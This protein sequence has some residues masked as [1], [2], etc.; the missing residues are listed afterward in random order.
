MNDQYLLTVQTM[1]LFITFLELFIKLQ[2]GR[3]ILKF[4]SQRTT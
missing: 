4:N 1:H 2:K 3:Q